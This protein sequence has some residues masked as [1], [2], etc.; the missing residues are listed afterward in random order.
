MADDTRT[1]E[2]RYEAGARRARARYEGRPKDHPFG[3]GLGEPFRGPI[4]GAPREG[5]K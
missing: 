1:D 4:P 2:E 3:R 5:G